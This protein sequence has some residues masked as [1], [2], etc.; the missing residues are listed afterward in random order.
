VDKY[1]FY[2]PLKSQHLALC[3]PHIFIHLSLL[4]ETGWTTLGFPTWLLS[5]RSIR[6]RRRR[7]LVKKVVVR[8]WCPLV[9][10]CRSGSSNPVQGGGGAMGLEGS[11]RGKDVPRYMRMSGGWQCIRCLQRVLSGTLQGGAGGGFKA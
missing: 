2:S 5:G 10:R 9:T 1:G 7:G 11:V 6:E 8:A 3:Q 4:I